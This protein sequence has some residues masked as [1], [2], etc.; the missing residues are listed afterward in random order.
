MR[1][2]V[3][4]LT[5]LDFSYLDAKRG[6]VGETWLANIE[7]EGDLD[8]QGMV[9]DFGDVKRRI[10]G[11]LDDYIDHKL[12]IATQ[13]D[14][15]NLRQSG[16]IDF[17]EWKSDRGIIKTSAPTQAHCF[18]E[19][20]K[21]DA[22]T[23]SE[24]AMSQLKSLFPSSVKKLSLTFSVEKIDGPYYHYSHGLKKHKGNCQRI[25][26]GHRSKIEIWENNFDSL[27][28]KKHWAQSWQD[29]Y[30]G[31]EEDCNQD[32][33]IEHNYLF[34]YIA[35]QGA[36]SLSIPKLHCYLI[37]TETT[38][39]LISEHIALKLKEASPSSTFR[40]KAYEGIAK[41]AISEY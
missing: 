17:V 20:V 39:E 28:I 6:L 1:L 19:A 27:D 25:A 32:T 13:A 38:V 2:F 7:L 21:I 11:W 24:W 35:E 23:V 40:V 12:L 33:E 15:L 29:I 16:D 10:R 36:F 18:V 4:Q 34:S 5:N 8:D 9:C 14:E 22:E 31:T 30:V 3:D 26:H 41:G 37:P